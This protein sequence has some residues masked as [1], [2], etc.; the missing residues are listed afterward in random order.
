MNPLIFNSHISN[1][2]IPQDSL[3]KNV[4]LHDKLTDCTCHVY[5]L[6]SLHLPHVPG[7]QA[8]HFLLHLIG[9]S[10]W[11]LRKLLQR[12]VLM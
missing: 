11:S 3:L 1:N 12:V 6:S 2:R 9:T 8:E 10:L 5:D 7:Q 4:H